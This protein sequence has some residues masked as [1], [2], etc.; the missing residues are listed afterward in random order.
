MKGAFQDAQDQDQESRTEEDVT[1]EDFP[2]LEDYDNIDDLKV[3]I[4]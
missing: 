3:F 2:V 4:Y 1:N